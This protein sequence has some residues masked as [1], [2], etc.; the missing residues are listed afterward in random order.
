MD[1]YKGVAIVVKADEDK[2]F[3]CSFPLTPESQTMGAGSNF[4]TA[5]AALD[6]AKEVIDLCDKPRLSHSEMGRLIMQV[7]ALPSEQ[8][9]DLVAGKDVP[10]ADLPDKIPAIPQAPKP[11]QEFK[12]LPM[13]A[14]APGS[15]KITKIYTDG[16][17]RGN[18]GPAGWGAVLIFGQ[19]VKELSGEIESG[20][21]NQAE[22]SG[23]IG[24]LRALTKPTWIEIYTDSV[25]VANTINKWLRGWEINGWT[26]AEG[27]PV[28]N[29]PLLK[30]LQAEMAR[31]HRVTA[32][33]VKGHSG[34]KYNELADKL[35]GEASM[36]VKERQALEEQVRTM[37]HIEDFEP[38]ETQIF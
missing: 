33:W 38:V 32:T 7:Q 29:I 23:V 31:H 24:G 18:P 9:W 34:D 1:L 22:L 3:S 28:K 2:T 15:P 10:L 6:W 5:E 12:A 30:D 36:R 20:T 16:S 21:N 13:P 14:P 27:E 17:N 26:N 35:A 4:K 8:K 25:Y 11:A 19:H 37:H